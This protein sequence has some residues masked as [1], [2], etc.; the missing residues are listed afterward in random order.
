MA[1]SNTTEAHTQTKPNGCGCRS[2]AHDHDRHDHAAHKAAGNCCGGAHGHES[3]D[4]AAH[5]G[6]SSLG[7]AVDPVCGMVVDPATSTHRHDYQGRTYYFCASGCLAKFSVDPERYMRK[8]NLESPAAPSGTIYTCPMHPQ[9]R[10]VGPGACPICGMALEP[11][12]VS[13]E[14]APNTELKDMSR[15]FWIGLVLALP[16][17]VLEMGGHLVGLPHDLEAW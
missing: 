15:R 1:V 9:I 11:V 17:V 7:I 14:A 10:Q 5:K 13:R 3:H 4:H 16:V 6:G 12:L 8:P 2:G